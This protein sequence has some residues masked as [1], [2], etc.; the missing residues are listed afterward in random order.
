MGLQTLQSEIP[1]K[2]YLLKNEEHDE[3]I[4]LFWSYNNWE[5]Y[6]YLR[7]TSDQSLLVRPS[8]RI[9]RYS[10]RSEQLNTPNRLQNKYDSYCSQAQE[11]TDGRARR[12]GTQTIP[13]LVCK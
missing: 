5:I 2:N 10:A 8:P 13:Y 9:P 12:S 7:P 6:S 4:T 11:L 3:E 1:E